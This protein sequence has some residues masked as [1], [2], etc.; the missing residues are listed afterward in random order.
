MNDSLRFID[1]S[2]GSPV[3]TF[4]VAGQVSA[5]SLFKQAVEDR[6]RGVLGLFRFLLAYCRF[7]IARTRLFFAGEVLRFNTVA[8]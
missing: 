6:R 1:R 7:V 3:N 2:L 5:N 4:I 8:A